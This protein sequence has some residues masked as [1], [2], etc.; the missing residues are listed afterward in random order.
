M[1]PV[2]Q[3]FSSFFRD[4]SGAFNLGT[5]IAIA[6]FAM[7]CRIAEKDRHPDAWVV[8]P[9][10]IIVVGYF[11]LDTQLTRSVAKAQYGTPDTIVQADSA[12]VTSENTTITPTTPSL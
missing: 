6:A 7:L 11:G 4:S 12:P 9:F 2:K 5:V 8:A 10:T 3:G 1:K